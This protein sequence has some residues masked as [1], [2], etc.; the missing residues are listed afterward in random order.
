MKSLYI[1]LLIVVLIVFVF[2]MIYWLDKKSKE[3][4]EKNGIEIIHPPI[5]ETP[6]ERIRDIINNDNLHSL[7]NEI[8]R[9]IT[10]SNILQPPDANNTLTPTRYTFE[11]NGTGGATTVDNQTTAPLNH[12]EQN[13][14]I[15]HRRRRQNLTNTLARNIVQ[16]IIHATLL[17]DIANYDLDVDPLAPRDNRPFANDAENSHDSYV[18]DSVKKIIFKLRDRYN[19]LSDCASSYGAWVQTHHPAMATRV[20]F[21]MRRDNFD[22]PVVPYNIST[23]QALNL[24]YQYALAE[25]RAALE[26]LT[27]ILTDDET[28]NNG[29]GRCGTGLINRMMSA[30]DVGDGAYSIGSQQFLKESA[31]GMLGRIQS[32]AGDTPERARQLADERLSDNE[33]Y[34]RNREVLLSNF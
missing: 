32:E 33:Y 9:S 6:T 29:Q 11:F 4:K 19:L 21:I 15:T 20:Q 18:V 22:A 28:Y 26:R 8:L 14:T 16:T 10:I 27:Q 3:F 1:F 34:I 13:N 24:V 7:E 23:R 31:L 17:D 12:I 30:L 2:Y 5:T 25:D